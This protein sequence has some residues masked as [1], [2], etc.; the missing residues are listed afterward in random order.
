M[1]SSKKDE[2]I[3]KIC[4]YL[5]ND[6]HNSFRFRAETILTHVL[7]TLEDKPPIKPTLGVMPHWLWKEQRVSDLLRAITAKVE[8]KQAIPMLWACEIHQLTQESK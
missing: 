7:K 6:T 2:L 1:D 3:E 8:A 4:M 5:K